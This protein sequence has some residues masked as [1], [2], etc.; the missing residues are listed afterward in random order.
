MRRRLTSTL[1]L[2]HLSGRCRSVSQNRIE[3]SAK[4]VAKARKSSCG[5]GEELG[6]RSRCTTGIAFSCSTS[7]KDSRCVTGRGYVAGRVAAW[8]LVPVCTTLAPLERPILTGLESFYGRAVDLNLTWIMHR[9]SAARF[10]S[11]IRT[12]VRS[13]EEWPTTVQ[14]SKLIANWSSR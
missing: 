14:R 1:V 10:Q 9:A 8:D 4:S 5:G 2:K 7:E 11:R 6:S 3:R 12:S 13:S